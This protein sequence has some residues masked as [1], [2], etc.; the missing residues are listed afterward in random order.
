[1]VDRCV[2]NGMELKR[3][4]ISRNQLM[5]REMEKI[6]KREKGN[7]RVYLSVI[8]LLPHGLRDPRR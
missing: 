3:K 7:A 8:G 2:C 4:R 6:Q 5:R 1:M